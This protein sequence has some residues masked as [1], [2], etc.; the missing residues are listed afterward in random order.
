MQSYSI[1]HYAHYL[2]EDFLQDVYFQKWVA[3]S[4]DEIDAFWEEFL[5]TYP[6]QAETVEE[7][8]ILAQNISFEAHTLSL[9]KQRALLQKVYQEPENAPTQNPFLIK[10]I[11]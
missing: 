2:A 7:A 5:R 6:H 11:H 1:Q 3:E 9:E 4:N 8:R 10:C